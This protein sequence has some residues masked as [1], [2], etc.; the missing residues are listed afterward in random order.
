[1][2]GTFT[3][4]GVLLV[5]LGVGAYAATGAASVTALIPAFIGIPILISARLSARSAH[6]KRWDR[7]AALFG[8]LGLL[9][10]V[11]GLRRLPDLLSGADLARP[12][13]VAVQSAMA[14]LCLLFLLPMVARLS[15]ARYPLRRSGGK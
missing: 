2:A 1:M 5:A 12:M 6:P 8:L 11:G 3:T 7:V 13:A 9:G 10:S 14:L 4:L 15:N